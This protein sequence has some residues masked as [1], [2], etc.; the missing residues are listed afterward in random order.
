MLYYDLQGHFHIGAGN[1]ACIQIGI[2]S[3]S[4]TSVHRIMVINKTEEQIH[5]LLL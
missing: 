3:L 2:Q 4:S 5:D 1:S